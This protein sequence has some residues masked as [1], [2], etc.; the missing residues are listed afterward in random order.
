[1][2]PSEITR[3]NVAMVA[4]FGRLLSTD[5]R[6]KVVLAKGRNIHAQATPGSSVA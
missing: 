2:E 5:C 1:M 6:Q 4:A 3:C